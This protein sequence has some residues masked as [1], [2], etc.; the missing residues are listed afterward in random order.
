MIA[1]SDY[2]ST[3]LTADGNYLDYLAIDPSVFTLNAIARG[4]ANTCRFAGQCWPFYSVAEHSIWVSRLVPAEHA[5]A[6]LLHDAAEAFITDMPKPLKELLPDYKSFE[7]RI[8]ATLF[9]HLGLAVALPGDVK[10][11]DRVMLATEQRALMR[12]RDAWKYTAE[13]TPLEIKLA[14]YSPQEAYYAF[15]E[16]AEELGFGN[17]VG[18]YANAG[19]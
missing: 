3:I 16:R 7:A 1:S 2:A 4:L 19:A 6:G 18:S 14:C 15:I 17:P 5:L 12:N 11:A 10:T 8:E 13:T 9:P